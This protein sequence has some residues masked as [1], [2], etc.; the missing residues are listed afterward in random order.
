MVG[1]RKLLAKRRRIVPVYVRCSVVLTNLN[2]ALIHPRLHVH[3]FLKLRLSYF[4]FTQPKRLRQDHDIRTTTFT[5]REL[6]LGNLYELH[7]NPVGEGLQ[8]C[9][10]CRGGFF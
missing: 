1:I 7:S 3:H 2:F 5:H 6:P 4:E 10:L 8:F 9:P